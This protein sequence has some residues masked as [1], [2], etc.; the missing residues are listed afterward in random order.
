MVEKAKRWN[1]RPSG[2]ITSKPRE[3]IGSE[4][5]SMRL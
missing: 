2:F 3:R 4:G 1:G 5:H